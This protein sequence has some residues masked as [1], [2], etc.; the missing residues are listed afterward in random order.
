MKQKGKNFIIVCGLFFVGVAFC[1]QETVSLE[2]YDLPAAISVIMESPVPLSA[3][4][5]DRW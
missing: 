5:F 1:R 2:N 4:A 3:V